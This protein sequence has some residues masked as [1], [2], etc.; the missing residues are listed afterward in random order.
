[1]KA[2]NYW[3]PYALGRSLIAGTRSPSKGL[4]MI[5]GYFSEVKQY[6][7]IKDFVPRFQKEY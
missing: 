6:E 5:R 1:M 4:A 7:D 2:L 3:W